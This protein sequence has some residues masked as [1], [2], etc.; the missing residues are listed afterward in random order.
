M[1]LP[2]VSGFIFTKNVLMFIVK[3]EFPHNFSTSPI[4]LMSQMIFLRT[5]SSEKHAFPE[6]SWEE[7]LARKHCLKA[8]SPWLLANRHVAS[9]SLVPDAALKVCQLDTENEVTETTVPAWLTLHH[10]VLSLLSL[11]GLETQWL[12]SGVTWL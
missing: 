3:L 11:V 4:F 1:L 10:S 12:R 7:T 8:L 9:Y 2:D 5:Q 6:K